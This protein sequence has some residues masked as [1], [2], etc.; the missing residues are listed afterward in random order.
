MSV[1]SIAQAVVDRVGTKSINS[2]FTNPDKNER[3]IRSLLQ[4]GGRALC[5][6]TNSQ[7]DGW[8]VLTRI[9]SFTTVAATV[10]YDLPED[11]KKF[12]N[13]TAYQ[14]DKNWL[15]RGSL[16][17]RQW[18]RIKNRQ[19]SQSYNVFRIFRSQSTAGLGAIGQNKAPNI[20]RKFQIEPAPGAGITVAFE[21]A[22]E[23]FW[24]SADGSTLKEVP[25][26]DDD[27]SLFGDE[28]HVLDGVWRFK[29]A[30]SRGYAADLAVFEDY[31]DTAMAQDM[32][33]ND[34]IPVGRSYS[35]GYANPDESD[36][37]WCP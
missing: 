31:R 32:A 24:V 33:A 23:F 11:F 37:S 34:P 10:E 6:K 21:Y 28:I 22:S 5:Q 15:M 18:Q 36:V 4:G 9:H 17:G 27:E 35:L 3:Q 20:F 25:T 26:Q 8:S 14:M 30:N 29:Q 12:T 1:L 19:A 2:L 7:G 16:S 13:A